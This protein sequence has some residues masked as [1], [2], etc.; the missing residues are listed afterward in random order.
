MP[1]DSN[2]VEAEVRIEVRRID[3][4]PAPILWIVGEKSGRD[5]LPARVDF[6]NSKDYAIGPRSRTVIKFWLM[7]KLDAAR[8]FPSPGGLLHSCHCLIISFLRRESV[9]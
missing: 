7:L 4:H 2:R 1:Q 9:L 3:Q 6:T 5:E 8:V